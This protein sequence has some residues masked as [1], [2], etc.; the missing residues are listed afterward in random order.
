ME[1]DTKALAVN[2]CIKI[3]RECNPMKREMNMMDEELDKYLLL[4]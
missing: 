2:T 3:V 1:E 4:N